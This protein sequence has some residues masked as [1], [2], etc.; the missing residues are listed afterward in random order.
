MTLQLHSFWLIHFCIIIVHVYV[1]LEVQVYL[2]RFPGTCGAWLGFAGHL[3][4]C[5]WSNFSCCHFSS[6]FL[7]NCSTLIFICFANTLA[8]RCLTQPGVSESWGVFRGAGGS[9]SGGQ[10]ILSIVMNIRISLIEYF[11][12]AWLNRKL[13]GMTPRQKWAWAKN[14]LCMALFQFVQHAPAHQMFYLWLCFSL[15]NMLQHIKCSTYGFVSVCTTCS[16]TS[17]CCVCCS[18][19]FWAQKTRRTPKADT[20]AASMKLQHYFETSS[21]ALMISLIVP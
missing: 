12:R 10:K 16:S 9:I 8:L 20:L 11:F 3:S 2:L 7:C 6:L 5:S 13:T 4:P 15:Y 1:A 14:V 17:V 21:F 18:K 19:N